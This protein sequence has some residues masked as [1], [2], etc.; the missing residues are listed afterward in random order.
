MTAWQP[1]P[2]QRTGQLGLRKLC[3]NQKAGHLYNCPRNKSETD[4]Y[5]LLTLVIFCAGMV[6]PKG[7]NHHHG[8]LFVRHVFAAADF[9]ARDWHAGI[10]A[11]SIVFGRDHLNPQHHRL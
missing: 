11:V 1:G 5:S 10:D 7:C 2:K 6:H 3:D 4:F 9:H 8:F